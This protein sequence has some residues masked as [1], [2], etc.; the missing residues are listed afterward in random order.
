LGAHRERR[1]RGHIVSP[2]A[3]LVKYAGAVEYVHRKR[4]GR[5]WQQIFNKLSPRTDAR[6]KPTIIVRYAQ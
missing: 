5:T 4:R 2:R 1:G 3:Q 6:M